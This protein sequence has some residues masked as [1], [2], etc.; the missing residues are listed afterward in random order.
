MYVTLALTILTVT[1]FAAFAIRPT[2][3]TIFSLI[4]EL[5]AKKQLT[6]TLDNKIS[7]LFAAQSTLADITPRLNLIDES[8]PAKPSLGWFLGQVQALAESRG[9]KLRSMAVEPF[10]LLGG[11]P[12]EKSDK[13]KT[14]LT[15]EPSIVSHPFTLTAVGSY[16]SL[17]EFLFDL[18]SLRRV[19]IINGMG[20]SQTQNETGES[21]LILTVVGVVASATPP[22]S[23]QPT[24]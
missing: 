20:F 9:I 11:Q 12:L 2:A 4:K 7:S 21:N 8:L 18:E 5:E 23:N 17:Y 10:E 1:F 16:S 14:P 15:G 13:N 6:A 24:K 3:V 19:V 22:G